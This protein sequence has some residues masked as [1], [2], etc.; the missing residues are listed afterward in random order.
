MSS[1]QRPEFRHEMRIREEA[2][3]KKQV[4]VV[5]NAMPESEAHARHQNV[6]P[7]FLLLKQI[8]NVGSKLVNVELR[9]I[10]DQV[11]HRPDVAKVLALGGQ[12]SLDR[13]LGA[14]WVRTAGLAVT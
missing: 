1:G 10:N 12:R 13:S 6:A 5:G 3:V 9:C 11:C 8:G 14:E 2:D 4:R 7:I